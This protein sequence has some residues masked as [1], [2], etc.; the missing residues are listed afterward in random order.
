MRQALFQPYNLG[1][2]NLPNRIVMAPMTRCRADNPGN[3]PTALIAE[4]YAQR[5]SA[6]LLIT[7]GAFVSPRGVGYINVPGIHSTAQVEGWKAVTAAVHAAGGRIF[8]QLWHVGAM[9]HPN[10]LGGELPLA[11]SAVNPHDKVFTAAG[12]TDTVAPKAMTQRDVWEVIDEFRRAAANAIAAGFDGV[13]L[14][15]ANG[16][17]F[18]QFFANSMNRRDDMFGGSIEGRSKFLFEVLK[19]VGEECGLGRVGVRINPGLHNISGTMVDNETLTLFEYVCAGM[20]DLGVGYLHVMEPFNDI[21]GLPLPQD[22]SM[23]AHFRHF[24]EG[25]IISATDHSRTSGNAA[26]AAG[27]A[28]LVAY[29]RAFI[30]NPDFVERFAQ[31]ANLNVPDRTSFYTGGARGYTDYPRLRDGE[32]EE[33]A[34]GDAQI[35]ESYGEIRRKMKLGQ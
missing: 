29:G 34:P 17:L 35:S 13:E 2:F 20:S 10:L 16:Y 24:F 5:A 11:P 3:V 26:I 23:S 18:H 14:H 8:C 9:S 7:E 28:D 4:Y 30:A 15:A 25:T 12:P 33:L 31:E 32:T 6:G 27:T 1:Q 22:V 19:A 21:G